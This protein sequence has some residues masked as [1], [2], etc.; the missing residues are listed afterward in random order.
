VQRQCTTPRLSRD[1]GACAR[2]ERRSGSQICTFCVVPGCKTLQD[3][4]HLG[5]KATCPLVQL[6]LPW[7]SPL[8]GSQFDPEDYL[9]DC[10]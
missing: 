8:P 7:A 5:D 2:D 6:L 4:P 1:S 3:Q 9:G 10:S